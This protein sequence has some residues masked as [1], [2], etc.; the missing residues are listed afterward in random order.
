M[1]VRMVGFEAEVSRPVDPR[2]PD[3]PRCAS[4]VRG[5]TG[6]SVQIVHLPA[7]TSIASDALMGEVVASSGLIAVVS[8]EGVV[9]RGGSD[10]PIRAGL[11]AVFDGAESIGLRTESGLVAALVCGD[12]DVHPPMW[13]SQEI[14]VVDYDPRWPG[15]FEQVRAFVWVAVDGTAVRVEHVGSTSVPGLAAKPIID[16][17]VVVPSD[18]DVPSA[19]EALE[20]F[21]YGWRGDLGVVGRQAF[22]A[23][24][25]VALPPHHLYLVVEDN[26]AHLDHWLLRELLRTDPEARERYGALKRR[27]VELATGD[28]N[29]YVGAKAALVAELLTRARA[30]RGLPAVEYWSPDEIG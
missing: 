13:V 14:E 18:D 2:E 28:M 1:E 26:R 15:W 11:G 25:G 7:G 23:P 17:D 24:H 19:I 6:V 21:G 22:Q 16:I 4:L 29:V 5:G 27:N 30:E 10:R 12:L 3:G 9:T 8:G 20:S